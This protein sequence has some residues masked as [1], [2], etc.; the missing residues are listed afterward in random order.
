[1]DTE[2][3]NIFVNALITIS[4]TLIT[5]AV[6]IIG[7]F[8]NNKSIKQKFENELKKKKMI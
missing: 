5:S 7:L 2:N 8:I 3:F 6:T 1:M 4:G